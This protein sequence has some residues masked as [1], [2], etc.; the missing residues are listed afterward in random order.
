[1]PYVAKR[2]HQA[3]GESRVWGAILDPRPQAPARVG[4]AR[5]RP[6]RRPVASPRSACS[7]RTPATDGY[8]RSQPVIQTLRPHPGRLPRRRRPGHD[9]HQGQGRHGRARSRP[10]SSS[11]TTR[12][13]PPASSPSPRSVEVSPD[14]TVAVVALSVKGKRHRRRLRT[15]ARGPALRGRPGHRRQARR[16][17]GRRDRPDRRAR[18]TSSTR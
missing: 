17:R 3:K 13:S 6:A 18:R 5:R 2:R 7:S 16:R 12:R 4:D 15:L 8:S 9:R 11:C 10:R 1:M 14:K